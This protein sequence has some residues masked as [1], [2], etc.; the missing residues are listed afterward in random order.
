M[1]VN[2]ETVDSSSADNTDESAGG[3]KPESLEAV[4]AERMKQEPKTDEADSQSAEESDA[5]SDVR[6]S[7]STEEDT[8]DTKE[9]TDADSSE[10]TEN[11]DEEDST[12]EKGPVP[13][14][15][16]NELRQQRDE[17]TNEVA[18]LTPLARQQEV[19]AEF[20]QENSMTGDDFVEAM[21]MAALLKKD[22][23]QWASK[24]SQ[25]LEGVG[26]LSGT[27]LPED[28][29]AEALEIE[30][31]VSIG[32]LSR[33]AADK[34]L[35]RL[36]ETAKLRAQIKFGGE[37]QKLSEQQAKEQKFNEV[38][39]ACADARSGW[40]A[41]TAK[42]DPSFKQK[43]SA[44][45]PDGVYEFVNDK[46]TA[47]ANLQTA[48]GQYVYPL[49]SPAD[50]TK[51]CELAYKQVTAAL[52]GYRVKPATRRVLPGSNGSRTNNA[53]SDMLKAKD[54]GEAMKLG[55]AAIKAGKRPI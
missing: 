40:T 30:E 22:P 27:K 19:L 53:D 38:A 1:D 10:Q 6:N 46:I 9:Q 5:E 21:Q 49:S 36:K 29:Q 25:A 2:K 44:D 34:L 26:I 51:L 14:E 37:R 55:L 28:L 23:E 17:R 16:F 31:N 12:V 50:V 39:K 54:F 8:T 13:Y 43:S 47:L 42:K 18:R 48:N 41:T 3:E 11:A 45:A 15:R 4:L 24:M 35:G 32:S 33:S 20:M 52:K 7:N